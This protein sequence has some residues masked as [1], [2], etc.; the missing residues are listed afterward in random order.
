LLIRLPEQLIEHQKVCCPRCGGELFTVRKDPL[1]KTIA[2]TLSALVLLVIS[3]SFP[4]MAISSNGAGNS[5]ALLQAP[6]VLAE[7]GYSMLA[8]IVLAGVILLPGIYLILLLTMLIPL[9]LGSAEAA[10]LF[11]AKAISS[12]I[13]W[14]MADVFVLGVLVALIKLMHMVDI[15]LG[16][17]F[18]A[19][20][21]FAFLFLIVTNICSKRQLWFW[22]AHGK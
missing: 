15:V 18:W 1:D 22:V 6:L 20:L 4:F 3:I 16:P 2:Y 10:S 8:F 17:A 9:Y 21:A 14:A 5:I 19:Y 12:L 11:C 13:P 7:D